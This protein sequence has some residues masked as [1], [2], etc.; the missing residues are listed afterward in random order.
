MPNPLLTPED[1]A[2]LARLSR[3]HSPAAR[4][5][6]HGTY[7]RPWMLRY[8]EWLILSPGYPSRAARITQA[9]TLAK[10][11]V[12]RNGV[13]ALEARPDFKAYCEELQRGPLEEARAKFRS[14]LPKYVDAHEQALDMAREAGDYKAVA[15][16][17]EPALDRVMPK[18]GDAVQATQV[19]IMLTPERIDR[20]RNYVSPE[21]DV[22]EVVPDAQHDD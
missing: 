8:A 16:I 19:T 12:S 4:D 18:K 5:V 14:R 15:Q 1:R 21:V 20:L 6:R 11:D 22:V 7:L 2:A 10:S 17:S 3:K 13:Y 9:N